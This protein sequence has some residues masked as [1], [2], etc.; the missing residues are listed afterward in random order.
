MTVKVSDLT[1]FPL[2][3]APENKYVLLRGPS[4]YRGTPYRY[5]AARRDPVFRPLQPWVDYAGDS[6]LDGGG[7]AHRVCLSLRK[8]F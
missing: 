8:D 1:W 2:S 4:G 7:D 5:L 3:E 6:V